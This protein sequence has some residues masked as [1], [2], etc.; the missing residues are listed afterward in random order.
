LK[1]RAVTVSK[2]DFK[3]FRV[4]KLGPLSVPVSWMRFRF[5]LTAEDS[6]FAELKLWF[7]EIVLV[8]CS[9]EVFKSPATAHF[10]FYEILS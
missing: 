7:W 3:V 4:L 1:N 5:M 8:G 6:R 9:I 2:C 10:R